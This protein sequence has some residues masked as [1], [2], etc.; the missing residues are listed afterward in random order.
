ML[1]THPARCPN[2]SAELSGEYCSNCGQR[3]IDPEDL[4]FRHSLRQMVDDA[5]RLRNKFKTM[6]SLRA[7]VVPGF[8]TAEYLAGHR[9]RYLGPLKLYFVCAAIFFLAAPWAGFH[10][11]SLMAGDPSGEL[12]R[13]VQT[14]MAE[15]NMDPTLFAM[16]FD[17]R[18]KTV[19]TLSLTISVIA[20]AILLLILYRK[21]PF[22]VHL[23]LALHCVA[24]LYLITMM[25]GMAARAFGDSPALWVGLGAIAVYQVLALRRVYSD[26]IPSTLLKGG[27]L[28]L[29]TLVL[30]NLVSR[31][32]ILLTLRLV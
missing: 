23:I 18:V 14:R 32:A 20:S 26:P 22:G 7:L 31:G 6:R 24:V 13:L 30:N 11:A 5:G 19:Y 28:F 3:R 2:C 29:L 9:D 21:K 17:F 27:L 16:R 12:T 4:S 8:L 10:L 15:L 1:T 25:T